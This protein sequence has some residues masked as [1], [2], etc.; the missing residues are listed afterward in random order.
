MR[1]PPKDNLPVMVTAGWSNYEP[2]GTLH[3]AFYDNGRW[4]YQDTAEHFKA[5]VKD[6]RQLTEEESWNI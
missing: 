5:P 4:Y 2:S 3:V 1:K 6:W